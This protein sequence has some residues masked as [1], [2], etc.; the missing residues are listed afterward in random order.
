M[1][2]RFFLG[3][4]LFLSFFLPSLVSRFFFSVSACLLSLSPVSLRSFFVF[5]FFFFFLVLFAVLGRV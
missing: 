2:V 3:L 4:C 1:R 5:F